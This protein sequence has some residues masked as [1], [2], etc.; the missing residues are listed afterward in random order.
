MPPFACYAAKAVKQEV[1]ESVKRLLCTPPS[2]PSS[3]SEFS[4]NGALENSDD[5]LSKRKSGDRKSV[6]FIG[7]KCIVSKTFGD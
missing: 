1:E 7:Q 6:F 2:A 5:E 4:T 3:G